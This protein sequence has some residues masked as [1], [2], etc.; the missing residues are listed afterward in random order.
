MPDQYSHL[1]DWQRRLDGL[2]AAQ[3]RLMV[4]RDQ[5][6]KEAGQWQEA[7]HAAVDARDE[8]F[9]LLQAAMGPNKDRDEWFGRRARL[10]ARHLGEDRL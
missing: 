3:R 9:A 8:A 1:A 5:A 4:E 2:E 6:R 7:W 10:L